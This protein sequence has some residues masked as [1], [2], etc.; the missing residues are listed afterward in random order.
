MGDIPSGWA[1]LLSAILGSAG[2]I[3][4]AVMQVRTRS[5]VR[6]VGRDAAAV[7]EQVKNSHPNNF[8]DEQDYRH[9]EVLT[10]FSILRE[11]IRGEL[12]DMR[13]NITRLST[14]QSKDRADIRQLEKPRR[15]RNVNENDDQH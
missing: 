1:L 9:D 3:T 15:N 4:A 12:R 8:R 14:D 7:K 5:D 11:Y 13:E 6:K 10:E 2:V